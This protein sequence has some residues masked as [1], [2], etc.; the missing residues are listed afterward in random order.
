MDVDGL[1]A[2]RAGVVRMER[3]PLCERA[4]IEGAQSHVE[5]DWRILSRGG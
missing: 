4:G 2:I 1:A 3:L 5:Q